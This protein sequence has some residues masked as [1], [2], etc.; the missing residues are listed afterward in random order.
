MILLPTYSF[1]PTTFVWE[2]TFTLCKM[3]QD[4]LFLQTCQWVY[5]DTG[6]IVK[7]KGQ[8]SAL[9]LKE[10]WYRRVQSIISS[11][12]DWCDS[13]MLLEKTSWDHYGEETSKQH[14]TVSSASVPSP[15]FMSWVPTLTSW[16]RNYEV[17]IVELGQFLFNLLLVTV[18]YH[19]NNN[20]KT[21][22][23]KK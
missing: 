7:V 6:N 19:D 14:F 5:L 4:V 12:T 9:S 8:S 18:F 21:S 15:R 3:K 13:P 2:A 22:R 16:R 23:E 10:E 17:Y 11:T 1:S 20:F